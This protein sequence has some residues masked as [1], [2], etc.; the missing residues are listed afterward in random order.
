M[1]TTTMPDPVN[2]VLRIR[3]RPHT[4]GTILVTGGASGLGAAPS[5]AVRGGRRH[6]RS[7]S[8]VAAPADRRAVRARR[9][10]RSARGRGARWRDRGAQRRPVSTASFTAAGTDACGRSTMSRP[11]DWERVVKVNLIGTAAVCSALRCPT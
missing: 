3:R 2:G 4:L 1:T 11:T 8:T 10:V 5:H 6:A 7:C 9:P